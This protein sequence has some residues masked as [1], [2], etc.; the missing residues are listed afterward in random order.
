MMFAEPI[1]TKLPEFFHVCPE[2]GSTRVGITAPDDGI[3][4]CNNCGYHRCLYHA[5][6]KCNF[7]TEASFC[8]RSC[9][10]RF[11]PEETLAAVQQLKKRYRVREK[12]IR[13]TKV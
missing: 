5:D 10:R 7:N 13:G 6:V 4:I 11:M 1:H 8:D 3:C 9:L 12:S 2:C